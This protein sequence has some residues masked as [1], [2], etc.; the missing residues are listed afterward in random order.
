MRLTALTLALVCLGPAYAGPVITRNIDAQ[1]SRASFAVHTH[2][3]TRIT[4][5]FSTITGQ[6]KITGDGNAR[7]NAWIELAHLHMDNPHYKAELESP[8]F[9]D[10]AHYPRIHFRSASLARTLVAVGGN[11]DGRLT[12]H[13]QTRDVRFKLKPSSCLQ[14]LHSG[15]TLNLRGTVRRSRFGMSARRLLLSDHV[16]LN[17]QIMLDPVVQ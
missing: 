2:W 6:V 5:Q 14:H 16:K 12:M 8:R 13:G 11:I 9:F 15:C 7:V 4:G 17:L 3:F 1:Q 10:R